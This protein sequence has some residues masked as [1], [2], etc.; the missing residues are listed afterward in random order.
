MNGGKSKR[1]EVKKF[2]PVRGFSTVKEVAINAWMSDINI[3][4]DIDYE[5]RILHK[6][7]YQNLV[8]SDF[9][10]LLDEDQVLAIY[11]RTRY[12]PEFNAIWKAARK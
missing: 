1:M 11:R 3:V 7:A 9:E 6:I 10:H 4:A 5:G 8:K 12:I 2:V